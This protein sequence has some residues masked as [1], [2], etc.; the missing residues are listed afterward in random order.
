MWNA[1][2]PKHLG[3]KEILHLNQGDLALEP[4]CLG[5]KALASCLA[6]PSPQADWD[7]LKPSEL[8]DQTNLRKKSVCSHPAGNGLV[9]LEAMHH[10][11]RLFLWNFFLEL[12]L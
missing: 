7:P 3:T 8:R 1:T 2:H 12:S 4:K 10:I 6:L 11:R 5:L 9:N